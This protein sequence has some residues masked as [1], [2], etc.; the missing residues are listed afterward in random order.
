MYSFCT[1]F[2][3]GYLTRGLALYQSL[4]KHCLSFR[5]W[6]LCLDSAC[7]ETLAS[8]NLSNVYLLSL[9]DLE[10]GDDA[11]LAVKQ[12][13]SLVEYYFT[14]TPSLMLYIIKH[15]PNVELLTYLDAD[16]FFFANPQPIFQEISSSSIGIIEHRYPPA[17]RHLER[18]GIYNVGWL[19]IR[20]DQYGLACLSRWREQCLEWCYDGLSNGR[21][22][23]QKYL[24]DWPALFSNLVVIRHKGANLAPWNLANY[25]IRSD[26]QGIWVDDQPLIFFHFHGLRRIKDWLYDPGLTNYKVKCTTIIRQ[27]IY[28]PYLQSLHEITQNLHVPLQSK[29]RDRQGALSNV[30]WRRSIVAAKRFI[31]LWSDLFSRQLI[32]FIADK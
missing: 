2:D 19:S 7:Y 27:A 22:A 28:A 10:K 9:E 23:D 21:F 15:Q 13:R 24:D 29:A 5:L 16:I 14:C 32:V 3:Y 6:I 1:Y 12:N 4:K 20:R 8:I 31:R 11:L 18:Y 26:T 25:N 17:L 30:W